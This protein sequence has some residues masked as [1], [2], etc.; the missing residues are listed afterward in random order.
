MTCPNLMKV[1]PSF[2]EFLERHPNPLDHAQMPHRFRRLPAEQSPPAVPEIAQADPVQH[3][4][5]T[6]I[7]KHSHDFAGPPE[8]PDQSKWAGFQ[9]TLRGAWINRTG[10]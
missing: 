2:S 8:I 10:N 5:E 3:V 7:Q 6:V 4:T 1:G 9:V